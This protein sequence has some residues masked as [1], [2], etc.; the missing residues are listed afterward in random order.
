MKLNKDI[1]IKK[2]QKHDAKRIVP[3]IADFR[4]YL[5]ALHSIAEKPNPDA[6]QEEFTEYMQEDLPVYIAFDDDVPAGYI[7]LKSSGGAV[8]AESLFVLPCYR[9]KG[10]ASKLF[11][12]AEEYA[13]AAGSQC[14]FNWVHP[15]NDMMIGF[16]KS[17][18]YSTLNLIEIRKDN[19]KAKTEEIH[20]GKHIYKY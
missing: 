9:R 3:L 8:F 12:I 6:A 7:V 20:V 4:V 10:I 18:G 15:N 19:P 2:A 1:I 5:K 11:F 17:K 13:K 16:L 14:V